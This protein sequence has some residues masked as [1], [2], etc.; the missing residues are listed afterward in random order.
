MLELY[1]FEL[2]LHDSEDA[3]NWWAR[4]VT[5][6]RM[7]QVWPFVQTESGDDGVKRLAL[8]CWH[9]SI[10]G[11]GFD[12]LTKKGLI[13]E[14]EVLERS[15]RELAEKYRHLDGLVP[16]LATRI[17][18]AAEQIAEQRQCFESM[19]VVAQRLSTSGR[20]RMIRS[21]APH[22]LIATNGKKRYA[23]L[24]TLCAVV[25]NDG[26]ITEDV[27][28]DALRGFDLQPLVQYEKNEDSRDI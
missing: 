27:I 3:R 18:E 13:Q 25:L 4:I 11:G 28:K 9:N 7:I 24:A 5:D 16:D 10:F 23:K 17:D 1:H 15:T 8:S 12:A 20:T 19:P 6:E 14:L 2:K 26:D 22:W 21:L